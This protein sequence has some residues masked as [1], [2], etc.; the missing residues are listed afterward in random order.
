VHA[1]ARTVFILIDNR[2]FTSIDSNT[3]VYLGRR[4]LRGVY[5]LFLHAVKVKEKMG[6]QLEKLLHKQKNTFDNSI[7]FYLLLW[8]A[9]FLFE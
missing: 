4:K 6:I 9:Y 7:A 1:T 8:I 2:A 5:R 3:I